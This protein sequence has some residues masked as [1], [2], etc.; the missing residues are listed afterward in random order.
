MGGTTGGTARPAVEGVEG[1][2]QDWVDPRTTPSWTMTEGRMRAGTVA[3]GAAGHLEAGDVPSLETEAEE[4]GGEAGA[5]AAIDNT[6]TLALPCLLASRQFGSRAFLE[7]TL[8]MQA[9][10]P[11]FSLC[12]TVRWH[13]VGV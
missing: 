12:R 10:L 8:F 9:I 7:D 6:R 1:A 3:G 11:D 4:A 13:A 5:V 2:A